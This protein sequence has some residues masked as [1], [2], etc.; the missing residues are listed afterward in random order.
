MLLTGKPEVQQEHVQPDDQCDGEELGQDQET[1]RPVPK[2]KS[3]ARRELNR[4]RAAR[5]RAAVAA[6]SEAAAVSEATSTSRAAAASEAVTAST[7]IILPFK[8]T[9]LPMR[10]EK[11]TA[12]PGTATST[13]PGSS[14]PTSP[15]TASTVEAAASAAS[16]VRPV[17][18][19]QTNPISSDAEL[20]KK[21]LFK[22]PSSHQVP[23]RNLDAGNQKCYKIKE[24]DLWTKL[25]VL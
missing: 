21:R 10:S 1:F 19:S 12:A 6:A 23:P 11:V 13:S 20:V 17:K 14:T 18:A 22:I 4:A 9:M 8:G 3:Q 7:S 2:R 16:L 5:H 24:D 15:T 25:L